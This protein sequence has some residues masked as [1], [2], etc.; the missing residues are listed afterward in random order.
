MQ[1]LQLS[2]FSKLFCLPN[3]NSP[4]TI[5][6]R[7]APVKQRARMMAAVFL[8]QPLGQCFAAFVGWCVLVGIGR[9]SHHLD[10]AAYDP[11]FLNNMD[12]TSTCQHEKESMDTIWRWIIGVG[13]L[14][15]LVAIIFRLSIP[16]SP[17]YT[18]DVDND[19]RRALGDTLRH[20][21]DQREPKNARVRDTAED[22]ENGI[23]LT[24]PRPVA[25]HRASH[26]LNGYVEASNNQNR[27]NRRIN[28]FT[29]AKLKQF[30][31]K[32]GNWQYCKS[33]PPSFILD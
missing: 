16:E 8:M 11:C 10:S 18:M 7:F 21:N 20:Y 4:L 24:K 5:Q 27:K 30:F 25:N 28:H 31:I 9:N 1:L 14:P 22:T 26:S 15:A 23:L 6:T 17:R 12:T 32:E 13:A 29:K 19:G 33:I 3:Y 2:M